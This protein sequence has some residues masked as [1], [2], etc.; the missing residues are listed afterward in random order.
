[1]LLGVVALKDITSDLLDKHDTSTRTAAHY[2]QPHFDVLTPD[3]PLGVA[4]QHFMA[5]QGERLPVVESA[6]CPTLAGVVLQDVAARR[7]FPDE[8]RA[9][10]RRGPA[11]AARACSIVSP[12]PPAGKQNAQA[13]RT[14][15]AQSVAY[16]QNGDVPR[17]TP[18][19]DPP[20]ST[21]AARGF[22]V[23]ARFDPERR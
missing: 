20:G 13:S 10:I 21:G 6:A 1:M 12:P 5:F 2:L 23:E 15:G 11:L 9:L 14:S 7:V 3:M 4:L 16:F 8:S 22:S 18:V 17:K 19:F